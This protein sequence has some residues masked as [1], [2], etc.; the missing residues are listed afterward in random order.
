[1]I[2]ALSYGYAAPIRYLV[3]S[4]SLVVGAITPES[5]LRHLSVASGSLLELR[6]AAG[7]LLDTLHTSSS[8][9]LASS[10]GLSAALHLRD[11]RVILVQ[12]CCHLLRAVEGL[13]YSRVI[14]IL[15]VIHHLIEVVCQCVPGSILL[16]PQL[17]FPSSQSG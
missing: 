12:E 7:L 15:E 6:D 1:M 3:Q 2:V 9:L 5:A 14:H 16:P 13:V 10:I 11:L 4:A 17:P 8:T